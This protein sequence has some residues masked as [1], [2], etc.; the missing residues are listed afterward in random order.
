[1]LDNAKKRLTD[2]YEKDYKKLLIIPFSLILISFIIIGVNYASTGELFKKDV[3]LKGGVT[4]TI[5]GKTDIDVDELESYLQSSFNKAD[6][7]VRSTSS[8]GQRTGIIIDAGVEKDKEIDELLSLAQQKT[9]ALSKD[10]YSIR[11]IGSSLGASF[12]REAM[13]AVLMAFALMAVVVLVYF[14]NFIPSLFVIWA[15]FADIV[16]TF[17]VLVLLGENFSSATIA[18]MLLL[19]GFSVDTDILL[20]ARVLKN[21]EGTVFERTLGAMGTGVTVALSALAAVLAGYLITQ[22]ETIR[23][24]MLVLAIGLVFDIIHTWI[25]NAGVLRWYL[26]KKDKEAGK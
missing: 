25:T 23:Q 5:P 20:T 17:A 2:V 18:A 21:K 10:D 24:I 14:R 9:G 6:V 4:I 19:I 12:F 7:S 1:M 8:A 15:V 3:S 16:C 22:S 26:E 13:I 11:V